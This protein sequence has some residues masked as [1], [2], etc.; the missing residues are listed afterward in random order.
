[1]CKTIRLLLGLVAGVVLCS[2][3]AVCAMEPA[4][5]SM[6]Y[7]VTPRILKSK[8]VAKVDDVSSDGI[9]AVKITWDP[10]DAEILPY[11][12][13]ILIYRSAISDD[14][15]K[16]I[17]TLKAESTEYIDASDTEARIDPAAGPVRSNWVYYY[18]I[19]VLTREGFIF[20]F[21]AEDYI[22]P[23]PVWFDIEKIAPFIATL[24]FFILVIGFIQVARRRGA[25]LYVRPIAG[26]NEID[27]A[28][29]RATEMGRPILYV[30]GLGSPEDIATIASYTILARVAKKTA[31]FRT[32]LIVPCNEPI[33]MTIA[34][35]TVRNAYLEAGHPDAY[36]D[37]MVFFV[38]SMQFAYVAAVNGL[39]LRER[40]AT[41]CYFGKFYAESLL[42]SETG[43][44]AGSIQVAGTD[45]VAQLPF[46]VTTCDY[47]LIGEEL[48]AAS[49]YLGRDPLL[50]G[51]LKAQDYAKAITMV[52]IYLATI[53][54]SVNIAGITI[55]VKG[56]ID[57]L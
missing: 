28:I 13:N 37:D 25:D 40:T 46:F 32:D 18:K 20:L 2:L 38:T 34:Q 11:I 41:N 26:M 48:Y 9:I 17:G 7:S 39:M 49:A 15:F 8:P 43:N 23:Q 36:S 24:I 51:A 3:S 54:L 27:N 29:G 45:E 55:F 52:L 12:E 21:S 6:D 16:L 5:I 4:V 31:E 44:I 50:L 1:M 14:D 42:L 19:G 10:L 33:V 57:Y 35:E 53:A 30:L 47:T 56:L 22:I